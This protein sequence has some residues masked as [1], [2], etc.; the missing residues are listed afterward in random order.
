MDACLVVETRRTPAAAKMP[1]GWKG[2]FGGG[3]SR[4][5]VEGRWRARAGQT[6]GPEAAGRWL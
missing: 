1:I 2:G 3:M 5:G 4:C 6:E